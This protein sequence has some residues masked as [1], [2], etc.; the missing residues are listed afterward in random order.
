MKII[1]FA[2]T[3]E[4]LLSG[5]KI[6]T[7]RFWKATHARKFKD[8]DL[9]AAYDRNPYNG[10]KQV[11]VIRIIS[12]PYRERLKH[13]TDAEERLEGG[14]WGSAEAFMEAMGGPE[15]EPWVIWFSLIAKFPDI[16]KFQKR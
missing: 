8:G 10:G 3:T 9:V 4:A 6:V 16:R 14:L 7:R 11:A 2:W 1:S 13:M 15:A 12:T 5:K